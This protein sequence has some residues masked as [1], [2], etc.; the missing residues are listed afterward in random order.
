MGLIEIDWVQTQS[1]IQPGEFIY[2]DYVDCAKRLVKLFKSMG[3]DL[4]I[5][6]THMR[7]HNDM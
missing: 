1:A 5:A 7:N 6:L 3:C 2:E 4:I